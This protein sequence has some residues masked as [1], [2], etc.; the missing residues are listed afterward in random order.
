MGVGTCE[1]MDNTK[2]SEV[3][4]KGSKFTTTI[5]LHSFDLTIELQFNHGF[6]INELG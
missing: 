1:S 3:F 6:E 4:S 2:V 5:S